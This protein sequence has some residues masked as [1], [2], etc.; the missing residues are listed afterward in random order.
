MDEL[1]HRLASLRDRMNPP[2]DETRSKRV[3]RGVAKRQRRRR[4]LLVA[5]SVTVASIVLFGIGYTSLQWQR[6][7]EA[8]AGHELVAQEQSRSA[9]RVTA[10]AA[11][12]LADG[13]EASSD[14]QL[15]IEVNRAE[16]IRLRLA[17]GSAHFEVVP[18]ARR[19]FSVLAGSIEVSVVGTAFDV[20]RSVD[21]ARVVV[22]HGKVRVRSAAGVTYL[23][24]GEARWFEQDPPVATEP[25]ADIASAP[26]KSKT[27]RRVPA[28]HKDTTAI[29]RRSRHRDSDDQGADRS[30][31][32]VDA[33]IEAADAARLAGQLEVAVRS[34]RRAVNDHADDPEAAAAAFML[35]RVLL[36]QLGRPREAAE[37][38][39]KVRE[40]G[41]NSELAQD[42]LAREVEAWSKA[43]KSEDASQRARLFI[44]LYPES[45]RR[46]VVERYGGLS[47]R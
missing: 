18:N 1:A 38:F 15:F 6:G 21:R 31:D 17:S 10:N 20:E 11:L 45:R 34:L 29:E 41:A 43:G 23:Q 46:D 3:Q 39:A 12:R 14:G 2:W 7:D 44:R 27:A 5:S 32:S 37:A 30:E 26:V 33:L 36:V 35:G 42:A 22:T 24:A 13:S 4:T 47:T 8:R 16:Q 40:L 9:E 28:L 19:E 25:V